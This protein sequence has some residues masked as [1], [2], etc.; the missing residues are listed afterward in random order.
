MEQVPSIPG[1]AWHCLVPRHQRGGCRC[2]V[3][4]SPSNL[5]TPGEVWE[6][7]KLIL[8]DLQSPG[9][10]WRGALVSFGKCQ[11]SPPPHSHIHVHNVKFKT[12]PILPLSFS[13]LPVT[14]RIIPPPRIIALARFIVGM[15]LGVFRTGRGHQCIPPVFSL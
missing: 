7:P 14:L 9:W 2:W 13:T 4:V 8:L 6:A 1:R 3:G 12:F 15:H 5:F 10:R 11:F